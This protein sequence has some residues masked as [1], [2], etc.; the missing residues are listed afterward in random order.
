MISAVHT[1]ACMC[2][3]SR[4]LDTSCAITSPGHEQ[5]LAV[6]A[7]GPA[8]VDVADM[9]SRRERVLDMVSLAAGAKRGYKRRLGILVPHRAR[10]YNPIVRH[11]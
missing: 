11:V 6:S 8:G 4:C 1:A 9:E 5:R 7:R 2:P 10:T 3:R